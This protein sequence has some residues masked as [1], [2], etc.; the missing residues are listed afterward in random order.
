MKF[1]KQRCEVFVLCKLSTGVCTVHVV[2]TRYPL[3]L[4]FS[5]LA[6]IPNFNILVDG[7]TVSLWGW[8]SSQRKRELIKMQ[9]KVRN[10]NTLLWRIGC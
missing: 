4:L 3:C 10:G 6:E 5:E 8:G 1:V 2:C 7:A 9:R